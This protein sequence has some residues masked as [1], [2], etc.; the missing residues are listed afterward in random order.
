MKAII[1]QEVDYIV[2]NGN[3]VEL[4]NFLGELEDGEEHAILQED[5]SVF[6][7]VAGLIEVITF[8]W[9]K[10]LA[11]W[12]AWNIYR[13]TDCGCEERRIKMNGWLGCKEGVKL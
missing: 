12:I 8:G 3:Y 11:G 9:G 7:S 5:G 2:W 1:K 10:D 4:M 13:R 6:L